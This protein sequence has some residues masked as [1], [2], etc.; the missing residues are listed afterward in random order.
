[1]R[2]MV[3]NQARLCET[4]AWREVEWVREEGGNF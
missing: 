4:A 3:P 2:E 1:M